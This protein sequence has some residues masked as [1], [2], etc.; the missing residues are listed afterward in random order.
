[1]FRKIILVLGMFASLNAHAFDFKGVELGAS[2]SPNEITEKLGIKCGAGL[3]GI[4]VCS[5]RVTIAKASAFMILN[6]SEMGKVY[7]IVMSF[8]SLNFEDVQDALVKKFGE[9]SSS[10]HSTIH[11]RAGATFNQT[12]D[13]WIDGGNKVTLERYG[14][15]VT[16]SFLEFLTPEALEKFKEKHANKLSDI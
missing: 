12:S 16:K 14:S 7:K 2:V 10:D 3:N 6:I 5:G 4:Q 9:P 1:M 15:T 11:N 8:D 13:V